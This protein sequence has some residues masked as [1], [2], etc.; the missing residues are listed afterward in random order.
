MDTCESST[1]LKTR[2]SPKCTI[3]AVFLHTDTYMY[4]LLKLSWIYRSI[5]EE[6]TYVCGIYIHLLIF[7]QRFVIVCMISDT[8]T[9]GIAFLFSFSFVASD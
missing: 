9:N 6:L 8:I 4:I 1:L 7:S 5:W 2:T 3:K